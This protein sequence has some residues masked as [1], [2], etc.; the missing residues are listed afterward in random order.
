MYIVYTAELFVRQVAL[1]AG[2]SLWRGKRSCDKLAHMSCPFCTRPEIRDRTVA[3]NGLVF[4]FPTYIPITPGHTLICP[5]RC[6]R[7]MDE[8]TDE[9]VLALHEMRKQIIGALR[10]AFGAEGFNF[11]WNDGIMAGQDVMHA[12]LH[13]VPR[14]TG[15]VGITKYEPREFL[16]RP[17]PREKTPEAELTA[18]AEEIKKAL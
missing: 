1:S 3:E 6:V 5:V 18:I 15:D 8:L 14:K 16:Y 10:K 9:E 17:G 13:V 11:A 2:T 7:T 4:A 12:H